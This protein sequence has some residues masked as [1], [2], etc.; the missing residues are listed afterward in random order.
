MPKVFD[1]SAASASRDGSGLHG[2]IVPVEFRLEQNERGDAAGHVRDLA[3][4]VRRERAAQQFK[5][6]V[7]QPFLDDLVTTEGV[8][9]NPFRH[10]APSGRLVEI[11]VVCR[12]PERRS[13][14]VRRAASRFELTFAGHRHAVLPGVS[15][16]RGDFQI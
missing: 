12:L 4:F 15:P 7:T 1:K 3:R 9:P 10:V 16:T 14:F 13:N 2:L 5:F 8:G 11:D 6:P